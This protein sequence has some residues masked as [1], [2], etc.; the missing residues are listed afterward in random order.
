MIM[1]LG[2]DKT[3]P[4]GVGRVRGS[5]PRPDSSV[6]NHSGPGAKPIVIMMVIVMVVMMTVVVMM[7]MIMMIVMMMIVMATVIK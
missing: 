4:S 6:Q 1:D 2:P 3:A 5:A 7:M